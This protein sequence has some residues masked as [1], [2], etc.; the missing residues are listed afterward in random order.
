MAENLVIL[1]DVALTAEQLASVAREV[2][3][4]GTGVSYRDGEITQFVDA[5]G[6]P[7]VTVFDAV[8]V[9]TPVEAAALLQVPPTSFGLWTEVIVPFEA[10]ASG[11]RLVEAWAEAVGGVVEEKL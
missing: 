7:M 11:R 5:D 6:I 10:T 9:H 8:A 2:I 1:S 3:P 4:D